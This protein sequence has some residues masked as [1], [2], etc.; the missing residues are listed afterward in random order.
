MSSGVSSVFSGT[1]SHL[2]VVTPSHSDRSSRSPGGSSV[3]NRDKRITGLV[4]ECVVGIPPAW[5]PIGVPPARK[6]KTTGHNLPRANACQLHAWQRATSGLGEGGGRG[7]THGFGGVH[8]TRVTLRGEVWQVRVSYVANKGAITKV[9]Y[10]RLERAGF[11][12]S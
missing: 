6:P 8:F 12:T 4:T 3:E 5:K 2:C 10:V 9:R 7:P 11:G 1:R